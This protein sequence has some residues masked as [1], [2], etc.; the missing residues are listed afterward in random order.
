MIIIMYHML[1]LANSELTFLLSGDQKHYDLVPCSV[2]DP[3]SITSPINKQC[4]KSR[5]M[6]ERY[7]RWCA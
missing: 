2:F 6:V 3:T 1:N 4:I 5:W 7:A